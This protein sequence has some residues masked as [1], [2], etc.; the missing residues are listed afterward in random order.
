[1]P[2]RRTRATT[3]FTPRSTV[4]NVVGDSGTGRTTFA[5]TA[6]GPILLLHASEKIDGIYQPFV[7]AGKRIDL[8][9]FTG[10]FRGAPAQIAKQAQSHWQDLVDTWYDAY[11]WARTIIVDTETEAW[12][13]LRLS[14]FGDLKPQPSKQ[15][16][17]VWGVVNSDWKSPIRHARSKHNKSHANLILISQTDDEYKASSGSFREATG[18]TVR[19]G[20]KN[21]FSMS[22]VVVRT[23]NDG[24]DY[25]CEVEKCW[26]NA[27][28]LGETFEGELSD[29]PT[30]MTMI[31]GSDEAW[32]E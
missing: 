29:F 27:D 19:K 8:H 14:H 10:S 5:L 26:M 20:Q 24:N 6:P 25:W 9:D 15:G 12:E 4:L 21:V 13:L 16:Q 3:T 2:V 31:T 17:L 7:A 32:S 11:N 22:D 1:M 23:R 28:M 30:V 18:N